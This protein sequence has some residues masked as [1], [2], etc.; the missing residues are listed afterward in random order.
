MERGVF[1]DLDGTL[2]DSMAGISRSI[3]FAL[4]ALDEPVPGDEELR[5]Y[6]GPPLLGS[7]AE[8]VGDARAEQALALYRERFSRIGWAENRVYDGIPDVLANLRQAGWSLFVA[9]SKPQVYAERIIGH[10]G[11]RRYFQ[12]VYGAELDGRR[13]DKTALL[14]HA[15]A[16]SG[17][18]GRSTMIGDRRHDIIGARNTGMHAIGV[19]WGYG[20]A[21]ELTEAGAHWLAKQPADILSLMV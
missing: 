19:T 14:E 11:L 8:L 4:E 21:A 15:R 2:T 17:V 18:N 13:A 5:Q 6:I 3:R 20:S 10:F 12:A 7:F 1:F 9:T 16:G